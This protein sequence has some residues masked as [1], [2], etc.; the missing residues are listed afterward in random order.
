[1]ENIDS[2]ANFTTY[3]QYMYNLIFLL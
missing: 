1:M 2:G 3:G